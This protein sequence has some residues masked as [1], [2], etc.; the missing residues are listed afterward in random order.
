[1]T[2]TNCPHHIG[3]EPCQLPAGHAGDCRPITWAELQDLFDDV[4]TA[5]PLFKE[6][7]DVATD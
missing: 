3:H 6:R 7:L 2:E 5:G 4:E 1:M